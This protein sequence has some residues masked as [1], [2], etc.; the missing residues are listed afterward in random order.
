MGAKYQQYQP[1]SEIK[2]LINLYLSGD[3]NAGGRLLKQYD[4]M[5]SYYIKRFFT[6]HDLWVGWDCQDLA[7]MA[8]L[9]C[10]QYLRSYKMKNCPFPHYIKIST[11]RACQRYMRFI[12][13][14][15]RDVEKE[16]VYDCH[17]GETI[18]DWTVKNPADIVIEREL[19]A[20]VQEAVNELDDICK[21]IYEGMLNGQTIYGKNNNEFNLILEFVR[22]ASV[23]KIKIVVREALDNYNNPLQKPRGT[24]IRARR[25]ILLS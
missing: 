24:Y 5:I 3:S 9:H 19:F 12:S 10:L 20:I 22:L 21:Q 6:S 18:V 15:M 1:D 23:K 17:L 8:K 7:Q 14:E 16:I 4:D 13:S 25:D 2:E 11:Y